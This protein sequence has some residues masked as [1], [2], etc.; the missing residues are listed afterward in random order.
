M[1]RKSICDILLL[2][3]LKDGDNAKH[4][5]A[6]VIALQTILITVALALL[7]YIQKDAAPRKW[8]SVIY[9]CLSLIPIAGMIVM[10]IL[11]SRARS[12]MLAFDRSTIMFTRCTIILSLVTI[13]FM[14]IAYWNKLL[15]GQ[16]LPKRFLPVEN[17]RLLKSEEKTDLDSIGVVVE[18]PINRS[19]Y[20]AGI[21][22]SLRLRITLMESF[23]KKWDFFKEPRL[24]QR[25]F[26]NGK[27]E[28]VI[29]GPYWV[30]TGSNESPCVDLIELRQNERYCLSI[31]L[32]PKSNDGN[33]VDLEKVKKEIMDEGKLIVLVD[34]FP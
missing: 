31:Y 24:W 11:R 7:V 15:P 18:V 8:V 27:Y 14:S 3:D 12:R 2:P 34:V 5:I 25:S 33:S 1:L 10:S 21:P 17:V 30:D 26:P 32:K 6:E 29:P 19:S 23:A 28:L 4:G 22:S 9:I 16:E 20:N 13:I